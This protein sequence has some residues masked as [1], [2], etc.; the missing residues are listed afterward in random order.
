VAG[1]AWPVAPGD[2]PLPEVISFNRHIRP[3]LSNKCYACHGPDANARKA[4]LRLD[5]SP[6][7]V[8]DVAAE[9]T[10]PPTAILVPG[11]P[12]A[13][14]LIKRVLTND[15]DDQ[16]PP[17][18]QERQLT[19]RDKAMLQAWVAQGG[20]YEPHWA[21][22]P[23]RDD[24]ETRP[25]NFNEFT[26][27]I[28]AFI[29]RRLQREGIPT[30]SNADKITLVRRLHWDLLGLPPTPDVVQGYL[31][32]ADPAAYEALVDS[33]LS[34]PHFGERMAMDWLD[35][36]R[37]ADTNGYHSDE[38]R[39]IYPYRDYV[40]EAFNSNMP[41]D[42]FTREQLAGDLLP[43]PTRAQRVASGY[44]R[45]NQITAEGGAQA[46][47]YL[48]KY[49]ADRVRT[50]G[51][52]WLGTTMG[53]AECHDH[54]FDPITMKDFYSF[55]AFF[56]DIEE[57]GVYHS[58]DMWA[59]RMYLPSPAQEEE[60][61]RLTAAIQTLEQALGTTTPA[62]AD[63]QAKWEEEIRAQRGGADP[64]RHTA[65]TAMAG[66]DART[67]FTAGEDQHILV[68]GFEQPKDQYTVTY[69][70][71]GDAVQAVL[72]EVVNDASLGGVSQNSSNFV[73]SGFTLRYLPP[74]GDAVDIAIASAAA[75]YEQENFPIA[76][77]LDGKNNTGW[78]VDAHIEAADHA[79][80]FRLAAPLQTEA[81]GSLEVRMEFRSDFP[82][83]QLDS[84]RI[85]VTD[86]DAIA[87]TSWHTLPKVVLTAIETDVA[88][89]TPEQS[90]QIAAHFLKITPLLDGERAQL[91]SRRAELDALRAQMVTTLVTEA[92]AEPREIRILPRGNWLDE[93]G[94]IVD[95]ATPASLPPLGVEGRRANRLDLA[96]WLVRPDNPLTA[97]VTMNRLWKRFYGNGISKVL[98]DVG[99]QGEWPTHP[100][101][102]DWLAQEFVRSGW[103]VKHMVRLMVT[104]EA[105]K[106][107]SDAAPELIA[108]D[109]YNRLF[110][111]QSRFRIEAELVRDG[112]LA[113]SGLLAR[114]LGGRSV[115]PYQ[116]DG[117]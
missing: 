50:T 13:S 72:L 4:D 100:D 12:G 17:P 82:G 111:R 30:S 70:T 60:E 65:P 19:E 51:T 47:E 64:W 105:Y 94:P 110:A 10:T 87:R 54:K 88:T 73:L 56:A 9:G 26:N 8:A 95:P 108:R 99:I 63:A 49:A 20:E 91:A 92:R 21:Y 7:P 33:L 79:A 22:I 101:L 35:A 32:S 84:F 102:L 29:S 66:E 71:N 42:Q 6:A 14:E 68:T 2:A 27:P 3:I 90:T 44:N 28:D 69:S 39:S 5:V 55:E 41:F 23:P 117:Y 81:G 24:A 62:L 77:A 97:R 15:P 37:Y 112:A 107:S 61:R 40:I 86:D 74:A 93:S 78:A 75:D 114:E 31:S 58:G 116:P 52:V 1:G 36:V 25:E 113:M 16:M 98:D 85:G 18:D 96:N 83:H 59:P 57:R 115:Y 34:S 67:I 103:D 80:V 43:N 76:N 11:D 38:F 104:S 106:R 46:K 53:C 89:R 109:P 45:L 48:A